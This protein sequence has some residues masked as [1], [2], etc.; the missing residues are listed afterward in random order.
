MLPWKKCSR[1]GGTFETASSPA[2]VVSD[3]VISFAAMTN[4]RCSSLLWGCL[5]WV[6]MGWGIR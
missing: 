5:L 6:K 4:S 3:I 2:L 1:M